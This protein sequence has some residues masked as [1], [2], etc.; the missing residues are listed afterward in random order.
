[1]QLAAQFDRTAA[2]ATRLQRV[3]LRSAHLDEP[4]RVIA[5][6]EYG[7]QGDNPRYIVTN[8]DRDAPDAL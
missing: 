7:E 6:L 5:R 3:L 4:R 8:L 2:Q 1:M